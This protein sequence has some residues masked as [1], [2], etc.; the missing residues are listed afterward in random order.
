V[1][2]ALLTIGY[3]IRTRRV[4]PVDVFPISRRAGRGFDGS[5][6]AMRPDEI[7]NLI[8]LPLEK[9]LAAAATE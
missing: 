5:A 8:T 2:I 1:L 6:R 4:T 7:E 9:P 3:G